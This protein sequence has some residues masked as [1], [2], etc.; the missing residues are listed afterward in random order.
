MHRG[1]VLVQNGLDWKGLYVGV[2]NGVKNARVAG[3]ETERN[4][5]YIG[6]S[7]SEL[8]GERE[9]AISELG[10]ASKGALYASWSDDVDEEGTERLFRV[11]HG[12]TGISCPQLIVPPDTGSRNHLH[13]DK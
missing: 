7:L 6:T 2:S 4:V 3:L 11:R 9:S 5:G 13:L 10:Q 1:R 8:V 12:V